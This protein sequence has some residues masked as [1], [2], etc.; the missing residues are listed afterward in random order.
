[1][2]KWSSDQGGDAI[3]DVGTQQAAAQIVAQAKRETWEEILAVKLLS[4]AD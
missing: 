2:A 3:V 4:Y 1:M